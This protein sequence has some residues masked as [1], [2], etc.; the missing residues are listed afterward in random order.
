MFSLEIDLKVENIVILRMFSYRQK[1]VKIKNNSIAHQLFKIV[2][3]RGK[4]SK[5]P[6]E[7]NLK[8]ESLFQAANQNVVVYYC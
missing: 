1:S 7:Q 6:F 3:P 2:S 5:K 4:K 8:V